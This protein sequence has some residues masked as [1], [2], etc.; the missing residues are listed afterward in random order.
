MLTNDEYAKIV[1]RNL[2]RIMIERDKT[3]ADIVNALGFSKQ[4]VSSWM[5]GK[6]TPKMNKI[7]ALCEYL[8]CKRSDIMEPYGSKHKTKEVTNDQAELIRLIMNASSENVSLVLAML[9]KLEGIVDKN[10]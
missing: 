9:R 8:N 3:Q 6:R 2:R 7:D 4:A 5:N 1:A 10:D